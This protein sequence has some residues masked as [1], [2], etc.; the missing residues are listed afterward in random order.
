[1]LGIFCAVLVA[2][3]GSSET[4][5]KIAA[6][7]L[8]ALNMP[9]KAAEFYTDHLNQQL[10][11]RGAQVMSAK[12]LG[13]LI[14]LERQ[15][16]LLGCSESS[17]CLAEIGNALGVDGLLL[18]SV[19]KFADEYQLNMKIVSSKDGRTLGAH[20]ERVLG[21]KGVL[22]GLNAAAAALLR[23]TYK[24]LGR[25]SLAMAAEVAAS[26]HSSSDGSLRRI[27]WAPA[28]AGAVL[29]GV[30]TYFLFAAKSDVD[31][32]NGSQALDSPQDI[33]ARGKRNQTIGLAVV[34]VGAAALLTGGAMYLWGNPS[35]SV[36]P[37]AGLGPNGEAV[38]GVVGRL[39]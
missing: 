13:A 23:D 3:S 37:T 31:R 29:A 25:D 14:G 33:A 34:S 4:P 9:D 11:L 17:S 28:L 12:E 10:T 39:P 1:M 38:F 15:K 16:Q 7:G 19:G 18:G 35:S 27:A 36:T 21:E 2:A 22:D 6:V 32:L 20:S 5:V 8:S 24:A 26:T 30:G